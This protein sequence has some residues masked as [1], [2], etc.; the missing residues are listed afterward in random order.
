MRAFTGKCYLGLNLLEHRGLNYYY[1][2]ANKFFDY[3][4]AGIPQITM[5]FPEYTNMNE[6]FEVAILLDD[7]N[8]GSIAE[9][10]NRLE[11]NRELYDRLKANCAKA[12]EVW[13]WENEQKKLIEFYFHLQ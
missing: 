4:Q 10:I 3:V 5:R 9:A 2:L 7:L 1:S 11:K 12:S 8:T 13:T 6:E